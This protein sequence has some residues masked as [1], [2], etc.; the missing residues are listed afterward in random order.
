MYREILKIRKKLSDELKFGRRKTI[1]L[2]EKSEEQMINNNESDVEYTFI[3]WSM[4]EQQQIWTWFDYHKIMAPQPHQTKRKRLQLKW[5]FGFGRFS[6][7]MGSR[8][9]QIFFV[10]KNVKSFVPSSHQDYHR[11][12]LSLLRTKNIRNN[13]ADSAS[14]MYNQHQSIKSDTREIK[15]RNTTPLY[16]SAYA[17]VVVGWWWRLNSII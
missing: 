3:K 7:F 11:L 12:N 1:N 6:V 2:N 16:S 5:W 15:T 14:Y 4:E 9:L 13:K 8:V 10:R 17:R